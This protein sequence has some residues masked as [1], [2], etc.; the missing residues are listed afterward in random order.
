MY[1]LTF[2]DLSLQFPINSST[3]QSVRLHHLLL[4]SPDSQLVL[5][6]DPFRELRLVKGRCCRS[7]SASNVQTAKKRYIHSFHDIA[8]GRELVDKLCAVRAGNFPGGLQYEPAIVG[9]R[10]I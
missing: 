2:I 6:S 3:I 5:F 1:Q 7:N 8:F 9:S 10:R 4:S